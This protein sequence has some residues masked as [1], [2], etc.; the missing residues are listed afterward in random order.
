MANCLSNGANIF[1]FIASAAVSIE[2]CCVP[3]CLPRDHDQLDLVAFRLCLA[4]EFRPGKP[5]RPVARKEVPCS[6]FVGCTRSRSVTVKV[7]RKGTHLR[8]FYVHK[9]EKK[10]YYALAYLY[11]HPTKRDR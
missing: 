3:S 8:C 7:A 6:V 4:A 9:D 5:L 11:R 1:I 10:T 2:M